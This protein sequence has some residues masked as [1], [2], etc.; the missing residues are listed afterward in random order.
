[1]ALHCRRDRLFLACVTDPHDVMDMIVSTNMQDGPASPGPFPPHG[2][3][4]LIEELVALSERLVRV[5]DEHAASLSRVSPAHSASARNLV[6]Y[7]A[8][9]SH[10]IRPLQASLQS[11]GVSSLGRAESHVMG[12]LQ[13]VL[14][15]LCRLADRRP[16]AFAAAPR[17][18][19]FG[20]G[21]ALLA[22]RTEALL[23]PAPLGR[24]G[25]IMVTMPSQA[26]TDAGFVR[27]LLANGMDCMRINCA[28]DG[29]AAWARMIEHL[30]SAQ[31]DTQR[32]CRV[33][34]DLAGPKVRTGPVSQ[35][36]AVMRWKPLRDA[37][38]RVLAPARLWL[39]PWP[40][41]ETAAREP[42]ATLRFPAYWLASLGVGDVIEFE[43]ARGEGRTIE[44]AEVLGRSAWG[45][46]TRTAY[47]TPETRFQRAAAK[48]RRSVATDVVHAYG[49]PRHP[50]P[51]VVRPGDRLILTPDMSG[52][53]PAELD[54]SG[55][56]ITPARVPCTL[57]AALG[58]VRAGDRVWI[59]DGKIGGTVRHV[60]DGDVHIEIHHARPGGSKIHADR[61]INFPD[62]DLQLPALTGQ[63]LE[64]LA[65]VAGHADI[66]G[67]S[68]V[69][70][71]ADVLELQSRLGALHAEH[72][73]IL[74][75]IET[76][77]AFERLPDILLAAMQDRAVGVMIA[78]GDLAVQCGWEALAEIQ[79]Q[80]LWI[81]EAAHVPVVW[82]TQVLES[83]TKTGLPSRAEITDAA[84]A[85][86]AECV[87]LNKGPH[88]LDAMRLLDR[89]LH[90]MNK[91]QQ[92]KEPNLK[93]LRA[94]PGYEAA[95]RAEFQLPCGGT[96]SVA[97]GAVSGTIRSVSSNE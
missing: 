97:S 42:D 67:L 88:V 78:R 57:P 22:T 32:G 26:A 77:L 91:L 49:I 2:L 34:M 66:A 1:V 37:R 25:R 72:V 51:I 40:Q 23:G 62:T 65:F 52:A 61:G 9:R 53:A 54:A 17:V 21:P 59:D 38:G 33:L 90:R 64:H 44:I 80:I 68:W 7:L 71:V 5:E 69:Q 63:D 6:H 73:G 29:P 86:R 60:T 45:L 8:L 81:C 10:D 76:R 28:H 47:V 84:S 48:S 55:R 20:A 36:A 14:G 39:T 85:V 92:K 30:R 83:L 15:L 24:K 3:D 27:D 93:R 19:P 95:P 89:I 58:R 16:P 46:S 11:L 31:R 13:A 41:G 35:M 56:V 50:G 43:D 12:N 74:L 82:A 96:G 94:W 4:G 18:V 79:E 75:K 87:M 70:S